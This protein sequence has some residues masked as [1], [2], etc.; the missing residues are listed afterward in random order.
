MS[1]D[2]Y[3]ERVPILKLKR[4]QTI[5]G[6]NL[7]TWL[8]TISSG[9][10]LD[11]LED[12]VVAKYSINRLDDMYVL[13]QDGKKVYETIYRKKDETADF[14]LLDKP[15]SGSILSDAHIGMIASYHD[16]GLIWPFYRSQILKMS[17]SDR[18]WIAQKSVQRGYNLG[19]SEDEIV[20][21][22][23][24][25]KELSSGTIYFPNDGVKYEYEAFLYRQPK[26]DFLRSK[27]G[28]QMQQE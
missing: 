14:K 6:F 23:F 24:Y 21:R 15:D 17:P 2:P 8:S 4:V 11:R 10:K 26:Y 20:K 1:T 9:R 27:L 18:N 5:V 7:I 13:V 25:L 28:I 16:I 19:D 3:F 22:L 12:H